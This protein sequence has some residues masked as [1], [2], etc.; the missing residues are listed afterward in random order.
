[1]LA[2]TP[3]DIH[4]KGRGGPHTCA[5]LKLKSRCLASRIRIKHLSVFELS[6]V[7]FAKGKVRNSTM[8]CYEDSQPYGNGVALLGEVGLIAF[9]ED[10]FLVSLLFW[11]SASSTRRFACKVTS[12]ETGIIVRVR[13][14]LA[15]AG[16]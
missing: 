14:T 12:T 16:V 1:M 3:S 6:C 15:S 5:N 2:T 8:L 13:Q 10:H 7:S 4:M 11:S 9:L